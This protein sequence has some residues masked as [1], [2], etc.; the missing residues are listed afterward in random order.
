MRALIPL[1]ANESQIQ[2]Y[3]SAL[4]P[5]NPQ[6]SKLYITKKNIRELSLLTPNRGDEN[7]LYMNII[8]WIITKSFTII[9]KK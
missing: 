1:Q 5:Q 4:N 3:F 9:N 6:F 8:S 7:E 2:G